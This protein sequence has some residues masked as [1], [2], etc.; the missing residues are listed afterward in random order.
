MIT[1]THNTYNNTLVEKENVIPNTNK[2]FDLAIGDKV[3]I[4][5]KYDRDGKYY[6]VTGIYDNIFTVK[7]RY[8]A[9]G[10]FTKREYLLNE[11]VIAQRV[12][13]RMDEENG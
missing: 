11:I 1:S 5:R 8:G 13:E 9:P 4:N 2:R 12:W 7:D 6:T 10:S 3:K